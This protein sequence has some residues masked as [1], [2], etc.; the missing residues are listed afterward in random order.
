MAKRKMMIPEYGTVMLN[1]IE[2]YRTR[3]EDADGK[4]VALYARTPEEL[5]NIPTQI[6][7]QNAPLRTSILRSLLPDMQRCLHRWKRMV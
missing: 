5:Y 2:Y 7:Y 1:G 6:L 4:L 3:I